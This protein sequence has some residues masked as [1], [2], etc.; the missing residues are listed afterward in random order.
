LGY[1]VT[2]SNPQ[3]LWLGEFAVQYA[4]MREQHNPSDNATGSA[5]L[6]RICKPTASLCYWPITA[7]N[8]RAGRPMVLAKPNG[9]LN[10]SWMEAR[11]GAHG[12][13]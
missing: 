2:G 11:V 9:V 8:R 4:A 1:L 12:A 5:L 10:T 6:R 3:A 7:P 13:A